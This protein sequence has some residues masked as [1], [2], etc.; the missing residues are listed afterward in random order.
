MGAPKRDRGR[1]LQAFRQISVSRFVS[2]VPHGLRSAKTGYRER[3]EGDP[4]LLV[5][6]QY[7]QENA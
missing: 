1:G 4:T 5:A 6:S 7:S 2:A 3:I